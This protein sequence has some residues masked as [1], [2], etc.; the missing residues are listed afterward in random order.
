M[1]SCN[2][3]FM[4]VVHKS[5][6]DPVHAVR[7]SFVVNVSSTCCKYFFLLGKHM[8]GGVRRLVVDIAERLCL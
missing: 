5:F 2:I 4:S 8:D 6:V 3:V 1:N 7:V